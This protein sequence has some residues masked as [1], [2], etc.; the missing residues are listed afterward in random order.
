GQGGAQGEANNWNTFL[1]AFGLKL[2]GSYN[3]ISANVPVNPDHP[4]F[5]GVKT[6]YQNNGS[7]I[8]D[9][10]PDSP[11]NQIILTHSSGQG[12]IATAE[13]IKTPAPTPTPEP[14]PQPT[15]EATPTAQPAPELTPEPLVSN[16]EE[17]TITAT[18]E[19]TISKLVYKGAVKRTQADE[20]I[21]ISNSGN[22]PAN[23]SGWKITSAGSLKQLFIFPEGTMLEAGKSFR[24]YTNEVHPETGGFTFV[25]S[26]AIW[27]DAGD[28]AKLFDAAGNNVST[29]AYGKNTVAGIKQQFQV[30]QLQFIATYTAINKQMSLLGKVTFTEAFSLAIKSLLDDNSHAESALAMILKNPIAFG[31]AADATK[32]MAT[33]K[34]RSYMNE[35]GILMLYPTAKYS[36]GVN[37]ETVDKNWIFELSLGAIG[38]KTFL[39]IVPRSGEPIVYNY[40]F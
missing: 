2:S 32:A 7:S 31:L 25:S 35:S 39:A 38:G 3:S 26:T 29:L 40:G 15:P 10:Q 8:I 28:E 17:F 9:L 27:N 19:V 21:E 16:S 12:L 22:S 11:L 14:T 37:G 30:P 13:F 1:A 34:L 36:N 4:L 6:L 23:I 5:G 24:V 33:E 18:K 20:Y